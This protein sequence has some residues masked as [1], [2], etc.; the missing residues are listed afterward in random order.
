MIW[1]VAA[2]CV[3][4]TGD[5]KTVRAVARMGAG[6]VVKQLD[7]V[8]D[9]ETDRRSFWCAMFVRGRATGRVMSCES[10]YVCLVSVSKRREL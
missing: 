2:L 8:R 4:G 1:R 3:R 7:R 9:F 5:R 6:V 10:T